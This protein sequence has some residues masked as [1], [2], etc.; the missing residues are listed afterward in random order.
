MIAGPAVRTEEIIYAEVDLDRLRGSRWMLD[1]AGHYA[2][3]DIFELI[4]HGES[5]NMISAAGP[6][7]ERTASEPS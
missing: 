1:V 6:V 4:V 7:A 3:P 5:R 2:R